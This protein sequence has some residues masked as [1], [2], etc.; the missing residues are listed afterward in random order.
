MIMLDQKVK[1]QLKELKP[2]IINYLKDHVSQRRLEHI[3]RVSTTAKKYAKKLK[4][5]YNKAEL[6]ALLHDIAKEVKSSKLLQMAKLKKIPL[7]DVDIEYPHILHARVGALIA[8]EKFS[9]QKM[10]E[11]TER[12]YDKISS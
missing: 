1:K 7:D 9:I 6:S 4:L 2:E 5:D 12:L 10:I 3:K 11:E 8:K